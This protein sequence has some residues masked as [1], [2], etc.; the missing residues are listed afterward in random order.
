MNKQ[1]INFGK[2]DFTLYSLFFVILLGMNLL[3]LFSLGEGSLE[4]CF[5]LTLLNVVTY[6]LFSFFLF[7]NTKPCDFANSP[8]L[9]KR[10]YIIRECIMLIKYNIPWLLLVLSTFI[11]SPLINKDFFGSFTIIDCFILFSLL[12]LIVNLWIFSAIMRNFYRKFYYLLVIIPGLI[13]QAYI[14]FI[15]YSKESFLILSVGI[16]ILT[17]VVVIALA[18]MT[19]KQ[20]IQSHF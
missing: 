12:Y 7:M 18:L 3:I 5:K 17:H 1:V 14:A 15:S 10:E 9:N 6:P 16:I 19:K 4:T 2:F 20:K 11:I 8:E 13:Y